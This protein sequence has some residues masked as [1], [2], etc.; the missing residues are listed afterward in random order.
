MEIKSKFK[1]VRF[2]FTALII[3]GS[4]L[5]IGVAGTRVVRFYWLIDAFSVQGS[6]LVCEQPLNNRCVMHYTVERPGKDLDDFV[7]FGDQFVFYP[8]PN[9]LSFIK[10]R[11]GFT[12]LLNARFERWPALWKQFELIL[13]GCVGL[14]VWCVIGG[15]RVFGSW[16]SLAS[17]RRGE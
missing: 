17:V 16:L 9:G 13:L 8:L 11:R 6:H 2:V 14:L 12:Y 4:V 15:R 10:S 7:P 5:L 3:F 1:P